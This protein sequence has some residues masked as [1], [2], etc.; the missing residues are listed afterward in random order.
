MYVQLKIELLKCWLCQSILSD[1]QKER[2]AP[3]D[4]DAESDSSSS[5]NTNLPVYPAFATPK[6][7]HGRGRIFIKNAINQQHVNYSFVLLACWNVAV[8]SYI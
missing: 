1:A 6:G 3:G 8:P 2:T 4:D 7:P 5:T